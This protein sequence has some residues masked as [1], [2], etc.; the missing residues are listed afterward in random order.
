LL[1]AWAALPILVFYAIVALIAEPEGNWPMAAY[2]TLVP[3]AAWAGA[4]AVAARRRGDLQ[5]G[6]RSRVLLW[7]T[8]IW[9]AVIAAVFIHKLDWI[10][11]GAMSLNQQAWFRSVFHSMTGRDPENRDLAGRVRGAKEMAGHVQ[12]LVR[13]LET[14]RGVEAF[15]VAQHYGRASQLSY[16]LRP[17]IAPGVPR[18][19]ASGERIGPARSRVERPVVLCAMKQTGGR[20]TQFDI[21]PDTSLEQAWLMGRPA[22]IVTSLR[23][24]V[25]RV[26]QAMFERV[27][28][29]PG[30]KL[31]GEAKGDRGALLGY[32][33][34]GVRSTEAPRSATGS[35]FLPPASTEAQ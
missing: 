27:E 9:Y 26:W 22:V 23:P 25:E 12:E 14:E 33:Y 30:K 11:D 21:W 24:E 29:I 35:I 10:A 20:G 32:G 13:D 34:R 16:Y 8:G 17:R 7:R 1:L 6:R 31:R 18:V 4:D 19:S 15:V 3:L 5:N 2:A 28:P